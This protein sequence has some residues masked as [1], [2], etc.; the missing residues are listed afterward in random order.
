VGCRERAAKS[1]LLR[2]VVVQD[3]GR[4]RLIPDLRGLPGRGAS[5]H[6]DLG[7]F[8]LAERRRAFPRAFRLTEP[9][10][11]GAVREYIESAKCREATE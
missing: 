11:S 8:E 4:Y 1:D 5:L 9:L 10:D 3:A 6:L 2:I 7:C